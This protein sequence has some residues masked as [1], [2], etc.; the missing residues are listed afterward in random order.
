[1]LNVHVHV[2]V[3]FPDSAALDQRDNSSK[4]ATLA[5]SAENSANEQLADSPEINIGDCS[6]RSLIPLRVQCNK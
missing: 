5:D 6:L 1:M 4:L 2:H 3:L